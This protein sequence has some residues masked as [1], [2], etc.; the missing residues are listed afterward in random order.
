MKGNEAFAYDVIRTLQERYPTWKMNVKYD[1]DR[2][3]MQRNVK[4]F[5]PQ[6]PYPPQMGYPS[7]PQPIQR[8]PYPS[9][10]P[11]PMQ[12][13]QNPIGG[14]LQASERVIGEKP[15][16]MLVRELWLGGIPENF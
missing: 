4:S 13:A 6:M 7:Y 16:R 3:K 8:N 1:V 11:P 10:H 12:Y 9:Y 15:C 5:A 14:P 2:T